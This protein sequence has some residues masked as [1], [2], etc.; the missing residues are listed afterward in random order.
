MKKNFYFLPSCLI[1]IFSLFP[2]HF[3]LPT[4]LAAQ[5]PEWVYQYV[6]PGFSDVPY[7]IAV[8]SAENTYTT[9]YTRVGSS[10]SGLGIIKLSTTGEERWFYY[11][12]TLGVGE[13]GRDIV[14]H[15]GYVY[16][17]GYTALGTGNLIVVCVDSGG[18]SR[19]LY[20]DTL[21]MEGLA[22]DVSSSGNV[23]V[24]G[25]AWFSLSDWVVIKLDSL[26]NEVWRYVY[27]GPAGSYDQATSIVVDRNENV[28]V[29]GYS[30]GFGTAEDFTVLKLDSAGHLVWEYRYD[31]PAHY[32][33]EPQAMALDTL[34]N[35]YIAGWSWGV[36]WDFCVVKIDS[37]GQEEWVYRYDGIV[38]FRDFAQDLVVDD[39]G[40]VYAC[41][42][43]WY[44]DTLSYFM[45]VKIDSSGNEKWRYFTTGIIGLG[46]Y[47]RA[48]V[49][50]GL[51]ALYIG[52]YLD[53]HLG[54][55]KLS[56]DGDEEWI[57]VDPYALIARDIVADNVG[58]IYVCGKRRVGPWN[59]D[60]VVMKFAS[61]QGKIKEVMKNEI[62]EKEKG[63]TIFKGGIE[64]L[65]E[66]DCGLK[67]YDVSGRVVVDRILQSGKRESIRLLSGVYFIV[68]EGENGKRVKKVIVL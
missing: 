12:D 14:F 34:G 15:S 21:D 35:I 54:M 38:H 2:S 41:G 66:E 48:M 47:P 51:G 61:S 7:A 29:G 53:G 8:D 39:T 62:R 27:D 17:T 43:S 1:L 67:V 36:N 60:I 6:N 20:L 10:G 23:Y 9:G 18:Q 31:G 16:V 57:Y 11:L 13:T 64:F 28:Y 46:G 25:K 4:F 40:N 3:L 68:I 42:D 33:D 50:D 52:G 24:A 56:S 44:G 22:I 58:N 65:P 45:V 63:A 30:T 5:T 37:S 19:W 26:G 59:D 49:C 55:V 32:R